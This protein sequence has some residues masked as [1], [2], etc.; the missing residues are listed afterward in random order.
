M[1]ADL[2]ERLPQLSFAFV[3]LLARIGSL[4]ML[5]PG[6]GEAEVPARIRLGFAL[7][8]ALV[9]LP[10]IAPLVPSADLS[11]W[12]TCRLVMLELMVGLWLGWLTRLWVLA[13]PM[14]GQVV[15]TATGLA[16]VLQ[17]DPALGPQTSAISRALAL[18]APTVIL[19]TGLYRPPLAALA[20]SYRVFAPG[21]TFPAGAST[22]FVVE[23]L[24]STLAMSVQLATPFLVGG[25]IW[26]SACGLLARLIPQLQVFFAAL[27]GQILLG[28]AAL[29]LLASLMVENWTARV[30]DAFAALPGL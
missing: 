27:P 3:L 2:V 30:A 8:I 21:M 20:G 24:G 29:S 25:L 11:A 18:A 14:A 17:P 13:L 16:N 5:L 19:A 12:A 22:Q 9:L 10:V 15:A 26:H 28:F 4:C 23:L 6:I 1:S 7:A